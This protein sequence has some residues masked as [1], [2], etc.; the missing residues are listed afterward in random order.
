[1]IQ[2][3]PSLITVTEPCLFFLSDP[4][5][6]DIP[7]DLE[8]SFAP[9]T[10]LLREWTTYWVRCPQAD[11]LRVGGDW[12]SPIGDLFQ[13][14]FENALGLVDFQPYSLGRP[15][16]KP[17]Y[18]EVLSRKI[19][20]PERHLA[21]FRA[22]LDDLFARMTRLPFTLQAP[23]HRLV[24]ESSRPPS[25]LFLYHFLCHYGHMLR[26]ACAVLLARP[27]R[28]LTDRPDYVA[29]HEVNEV[30]GETLLQIL[31]AGEEL[32]PA[33]AL[34]LGGRLRGHAP[35][36]V[37]QRRS[38]ETFDTP[39]NRFA[40]A[41]LRSVLAAAESLPDQ[42]WWRQVPPHQ[43]RSIRETSRLVQEALRHPAFRNVGAKLRV[44][45]ASP[46]LQRR[47]GYR[48]LLAL[49]EVFHHARRPLFAPLEQAI[50]VK[51]IAK[52]YEMWT[53]FALAETIGSFLGRFPVLHLSASDEGGLGWTSEARYGPG[54]TLCYNRYLPSYSLPMRPDYTWRRGGRDDLVLDAK[55]RLAPRAFT[56]PTDGS[57]PTDGAPRNEDL[58]KMHAYRDALGVRAAVALYPGSVPIFYD[59]GQR[60]VELSLEGLFLGERSGV[61]AFPMTPSSSVTEGDEWT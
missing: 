15:L 50:E 57:P 21:F 16:F 35:T 2:A 41:F 8:G 24:T 26:T 30:D 18:A 42:R 56:N 27:H 20:S 58:L 9:A 1:M 7:A 54:Q 11:A 51:D 53:F 3:P 38:E 49:W 32:A 52:L 19:P 13:I 36:R 47:E 44:P 28:A 17:I 34:P 55:F 12:A 25:P 6:E 22:V 45:Y 46:S 33:L 31:H 10:V 43:S 37:W 39:E 5:P 23:T 61:G 14:R 59:H 29:P 60:A 40:V 48:D 4:Q